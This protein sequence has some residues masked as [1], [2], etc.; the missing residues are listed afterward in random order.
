MIKKILL[1]TLSILF[2]LILLIMLLLPGFAKRY[3]INNSKDL[4]GR[5]IDIENL[6]LNYFTG[7]IRVTDFKMFEQDENEIFASFDTLIVNLEPF[8]LFR[9]DFVMESFYL[10]GLHTKIIQYDSTFN[11]DDIIAFHSSGTDTT[12][13]ETDSDDPF[14][15]HLSNIELKGAEF[16]F[17]DRT[18]NKITPINDLSFFIPYIGWNQEYQS[19]AGLKFAF[20][21][22]GFFES[23]IQ[24]DPIGGD[25]KAGITIHHL[26]LNAFQEYAA[27]Y[28]NINKMDGT[29]NS[30]IM[31]EGNI[32]EAEKS[33]I[34]GYAEIYDFIMEDQQDK[35]F[36]GA[37]KLECKLKEVD[38]F[39]ASYIIDSLILIEPYVYFELDTLSNNF[40]DIFNLNLDTDTMQEVVYTADS[41]VLDTSDPLFYAVN[42]IRI[43]RGEADYTDKLT[44][45][46]FDYNLSEIE[47]TADSILS[48]SDW[49][50]TYSTMLLNKRGK[51]V[52]EV[53]LDP[54]NPYDIILDYVITD[55]QL[56]DLNIYSRHYMGFPILYGDMYYKSHTEILNN[57][58]K[59]E[60]KLIIN[61][62]EVGDKKGGLYNLPMKFALF[63]LKDRDGVIDLDVPVR[64]NL[65]DPT[66]SIGKIVWNTFKNL[67]IKVAAAPFDFLA[68][69]ISVDP[70]DIKAIEYAYLDTTFTAQKQ[71]QLDLLLELEQKKDNLEIELAYFNDV[72]MEKEQVA[73]AE[74]G[75]LFSTKTGLDYRNDQIAFVDFLK[76]ETKSDAVD[77]V[78][79]SKTLIPEAT[80][81]TI[82]IQLK[83]TRIERIEQYLSQKS[84]TT[85]I[86]IYIPDP[87]S[88]KNVGSEPVFEVKYTMRPEVVKNENSK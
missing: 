41:L 35:K 2:I 82:S 66:V 29:F 43:D 86:K 7:M 47:M 20:K 87:K 68:G 50:N 9:S 80:I 32:K 78:L 58:L 60:N 57:Q 67:I 70:K 61:N 38:N 6:K 71:R 17:D 13:S 3:T 49:I 44:G 21:N 5:Q 10:K 46:P 81:D 15:F 69:I 27:S 1:W 28:V 16:I 74:A 52:A 37:K 18:I 33:L 79:A 83:N 34:T 40:Y 4:I 42:H 23:S 30:R 88:P 55:F 63:L 53:G 72:E 77:I 11:F 62:A 51:L 64:G 75:K 76:K 8:Q 54:A 85:Q 65:D 59:S 56:S 22:D 39:N 45:S 73:I 12:S 26:Y 24:I 84:D 31:I 14:R 25:F 48:S 19:E 36:L